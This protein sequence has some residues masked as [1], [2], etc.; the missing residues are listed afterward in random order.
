MPDTNLNIRH[1]LAESVSRNDNLF[2]LISPGWGTSGYYSTQVLKEDGP[3]VFTSGL[4]MYWNHPTKHEEQQRPEGDLRY[5]AAEL[6]SDAEY[7]ENGP[8]GPGLY[9]NGKIFEQYKEPIKDMAEHIGL[10]IRAGGETSPGEAEGRRGPIVEKISYAKSVDFVTEAGAGG[11]IVE[12][13]ESLNPHNK[14]GVKMEEATKDEV[15]QL[16]AEMCDEEYEEVMKMEKDALKQAID[17][18]YKEKYDDN[19]EEMDEAH[20]KK[21]FPE[22]VESIRKEEKD[23]LYDDKGKLKEAKKM[24]EKQIQELQESLNE[25]NT[26]KEKLKERLLLKEAKDIVSSKVS[27]A[28][29]PEITK[30][31]LIESLSKNPPVTDGEIDTEEYDTAI[32]EA[33]KEEV[34]Y[35]AEAVQAGKVTGMGDSDKGEED[36][37]KVDAEYKESLSKLGIS[38][39]VL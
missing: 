39:E 34:N 26:E 7:M 1:N 36:S 3:K 30:N 10:S 16:I 37:E 14:R 17:Q 29:I 2:K 23:K 27:E 28:D 21:N 5:L 25:A 19:D 9:A 32:D 8:E 31:R 11:E 6:T 13:F 18:K 38:K 33:I 22:I 12:L 20:I 24:S 35:L 4:K 15:I